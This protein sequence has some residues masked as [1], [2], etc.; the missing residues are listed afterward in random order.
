MVGKTPWPAKP[1]M[2]SPNAKGT[3][4]GDGGYRLVCCGSQSDPNPVGVERPI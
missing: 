1:D 4:I 2:I 3:T